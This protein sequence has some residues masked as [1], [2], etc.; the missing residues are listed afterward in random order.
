MSNFGSWLRE[1]REK[2]G[3]TQWQLANRALPRNYTRPAANFSQVILWEH[4]D[5]PESDETL[6][7][8]A[9]VL[10]VDPDEAFHAA[11]RLTPDL[12]RVMDRLD[13]EARKAIRKGFTG[14]R[15]AK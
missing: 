15:E 4:E 7:K 12:Q 9:K 3:L 6:L 8:L 11:G 2:K 5:V 14:K 13:V 1:K 10:E